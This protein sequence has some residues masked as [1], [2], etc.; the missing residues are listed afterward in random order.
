M[1]AAGDAGKGSSYSLN[2][3]IADISFGTI[4]VYPESLGVPFSGLGGT[5]NYTWTNEY[6]IKSRVAI[7][8]QLNKPFIIEEFGQTP[9]YGNTSGVANPRWLELVS[10]CVSQP[11]WHASSLGTKQFSPYQGRG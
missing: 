9:D 5:D 4:H 2:T 3:A 8:A 10:L 1:F 7:A 11:L 6:L